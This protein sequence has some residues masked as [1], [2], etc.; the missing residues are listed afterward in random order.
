VR[1]QHR[2]VSACHLTNI[3]MRL[4]R[5]LTWDAKDEKF[6]D[7]SEADGWLRR[8]PREPYGVPA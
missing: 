6:V 3:A 1:I 2:T 5:K 8:E 4:G 7:D